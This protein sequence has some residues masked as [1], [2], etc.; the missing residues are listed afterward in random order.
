MTCN[1]KTQKNK[2]T[3]QPVY[4]KLEILHVPQELNSLNKL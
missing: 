2:I 3:C 1:K 4:N